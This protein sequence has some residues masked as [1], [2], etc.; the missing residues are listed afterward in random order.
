MLRD[1]T[2]RVGN[3]MVRQ[4]Q[5]AVIAVAAG[6]VLSPSPGI[7]QQTKTTTFLGSEINPLPGVYLVLKDVNVRARPETKSKRVGRL[8]LRD[9]VE[10]PGRDRG[11]WIAVSV[12]GKDL[13]FVFEPTLMLVLDGAFEDDLKGK[14]TPSSEA[15]KTPPCNYTIRFAGKSPAEGQLFE[16][17]DYEVRWHCGVGKQSARFL[18]PM[19]MTEGS[20]SGD[21]RALYQ[22]TID[23][24]EL[25]DETEDQFSTNMLFDRKAGVVRFD[26]VNV[27][28]LGGKPAPAEAK[29]E[30]VAEALRQAVAMAHRSWTAKAWATLMGTAR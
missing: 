23:V 26:A 2:T 6:F 30:S 4:T 29:A 19:Y 16:F 1:A 21:S 10:S 17:A 28:D 13:G 22:I 18:T 25:G 12:G 11:P 20:Y 15:P 9:R 7:A 27:K 8:K 3:L 14:L 5:M 24:P